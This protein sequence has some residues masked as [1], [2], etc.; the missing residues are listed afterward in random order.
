MYLLGYIDRNPSGANARIRVKILSGKY[1]KKLRLPAWT[2]E[3]S[4]MSIL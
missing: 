1:A 3:L 4:S 2:V